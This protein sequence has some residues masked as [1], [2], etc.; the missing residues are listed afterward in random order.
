V[1]EM[2]EIEKADFDQ[3]DFSLRTTKGRVLVKGV[4]NPPVKGHWILNEWFNLLPATYENV[5]QHTGIDVSDVPEKYLD[6]FF[7]MVPKKDREDT[8]FIF[9]NYQ[10]N[11]ANLD[12]NVI[13]KIERVKVEDPEYYLHQFVGL[14]PSGMT[15]L[16]FKK[17]KTISVEEYEAL[18][19][20]K[21]Y[22][23][24]FGSNDPSVLVEVMLHDNNIYLRTKFY[25]PHMTIDEIWEIIMGI[26]EE[27][28]AD[29]Q[30]KQ[31]IESL[32]AK[33]GCWVTGSVKGPD[34]IT[35]GIRKLKGYNIYIC[36]DSVEMIDETNNYVWM[37]DKYGIPTDRPIDKHNHAWDATRYAIEDISP[38]DFEMKANY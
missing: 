36:E 23:M 16:V 18:P 34:S 37:T 13:T 3:L 28:I 21:R 5:L 9:S 22:G 20:N 10:G 7:V 14:V 19:F 30:A 8:A 17:Y 24:D 27:I 29:G 15:G 25:K 33:G 38:H 6:G 11:L 2:E 26:N 1:E 32:N 12:P 4:F 31:T 35:A